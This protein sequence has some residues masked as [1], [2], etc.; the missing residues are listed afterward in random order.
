LFVPFGQPSNLNQLGCSPPPANALTTLSHQVSITSPLVTIQRNNHGC[1][2]GCHNDTSLP[3]CDTQ[4]S[5]PTLHY[6]LAGY[7]APG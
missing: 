2:W 7:L 6:W 3:S 4:S 1:T 5:N